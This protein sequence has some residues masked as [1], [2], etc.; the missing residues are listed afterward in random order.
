M[1]ELVPHR[2]AGELGGVA[3]EVRA[4][5]SRMLLDCGVGG[6]GDEEWTDEIGSLDGVWVSH[7]HLDHGGALPALLSGRPFLGG[8]CSAATQRL[9]ELTLPAVDGVDETRARDVA[10]ALA[11]ISARRYTDVSG[12]VRLMPFPA[13]HVLGAR[14]VAVEAGGPES[15]TTRLLYTGDFCCHDQPVLPGA[16]FPSTDGD[17][18]LDTLVMEGVLATNREADETELTDEWSR[19]VDFADTDGPVLIPV[20]PVGEAV[21]VIAALREAATELVGDSS[22]EPMVAAYDRWAEPGDL[23]EVVE[24]ASPEDFSAAFERGATIVAAGGQLEPNTAAHRA[25]GDV[26]ESSKARIA[27]L[28][29]AYPSTPAGR[30]LDTGEGGE[31]RLRP[32]F[33]R[34]LR[35]AVDSF[36]L[37]SHAPRSQLIA[38]VEAL[39]PNRVVLVHGRESH[40]QTLYRVVGASDYD[41][42]IEVPSS[43]DV[44]S[45]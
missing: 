9:L 41:G 4:G 18:T 3:L 6:D 31:F 39:Q 34:T 40:L 45:V 30:L 15:E 23:R 21:E 38:T 1:A 14:T 42:D 36:T 13:G 16:R 26:I 35:A 28:N 7:A 37:P 17:F 8:W 24:F 20:S 11:P 25:A 19:L 10:D 22:L 32:D 33:P 43:G 27:V 2:G 29:R 44:V 12:E 5:D